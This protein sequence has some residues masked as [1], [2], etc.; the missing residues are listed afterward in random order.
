MLENHTLHTQGKLVT[1]VFV[2][3][4]SVFRIVKAL[5]NF[6]YHVNL[7]RDGKQFQQIYHRK[8]NWLRIAL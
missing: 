7:L 5:Y 8:S 3:S 2:N 6:A 1:K 4:I